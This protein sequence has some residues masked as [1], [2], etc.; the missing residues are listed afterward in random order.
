MSRRVNYACWLW[1][2]KGG[3]VRYVGWGPFEGQ[4]PAKI[5]FEKRHDDDSDLHRWL[6]DCPTE[7]SRVAVG[8][9]AM[10]EADA[11]ILVSLYR[12]RHEASTLASRGSQSRSG[13]G[14]SKGIVY[15]DKLYNDRG[16]KV[17]PSVRAAAK[18]FELNPS[19]ITRHCQN[20]KR[21]DWVYIGDFDYE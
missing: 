13:G 17:F 6:Q 21:S 16:Y 12:K 7:P 14:A 19:T 9:V 10:S 8:A 3:V 15:V 20:P 18:A 11:R 2:D 4:H 1:L 5:R